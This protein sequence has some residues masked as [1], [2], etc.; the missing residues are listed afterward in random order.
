VKNRTDPRAD[1]TWA[2]LGRAKAGE[3]DAVERLFARYVP[4]L[5][6]WARGRLPVWAR[7]LTDTHDLVQ[8]TLLQTFK[9]IDTIEY[10]GEGSFHAY[11]RQALVNRIREQLRRSSRRPVPIE[12]TEEHVDPEPSPLDRAIDRRAWRDYEQALAKLRPDEQE[13][14]VGR[15]ELGLTYEELAILQD[16]PSADAARK[17]ARRALTRLIQEMDGD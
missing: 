11:L 10:R 7:D 17:A 4:R 13:A 8:D 9:K 15:L 16:R 2:L 3:Q 12:I 6:R 14:I 5:R 1:E